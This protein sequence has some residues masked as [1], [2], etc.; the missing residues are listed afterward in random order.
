MLCM[1]LFLCLNEM[2]APLVSMGFLICED[3]HWKS[4]LTVYYEMAIFTFN[5]CSCC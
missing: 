5:F 1:F 2:N 4:K 3:N